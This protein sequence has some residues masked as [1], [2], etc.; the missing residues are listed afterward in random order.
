MLSAMM[1][2]VFVAGSLDW[3]SHEG[4]RNKMITGLMWKVTDSPLNLWPMQDRL[5]PP[6]WAKD[7]HFAGSLDEAIWPFI[8]EWNSPGHVRWLWLET[9]PSQLLTSSTS[10]E[11][12]P[13]RP[14]QGPHPPPAL[15]PESPHG[16]HLLA[17]YNWFCLGAAKLWNNCALWD[18]LCQDEESQLL[19]SNDLSLRETTKHCRLH[20]GTGVVQ[21]NFSRKK[22][23][24]GG[25]GSPFF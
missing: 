3:K 13:S 11:W 15:H 14:T 9:I 24:L 2:V 20:C 17:S 19:L 10:V 22:D 5:K 21:G 12:Q 1:Q 7:E 6:S 16:F 23:R 4:F 25:K 8:F 18:L